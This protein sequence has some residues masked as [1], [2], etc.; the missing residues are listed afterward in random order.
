MI[1][2][3]MTAKWTGCLRT[4][5]GLLLP[6][7]SLGRWTTDSLLDHDIFLSV[8]LSEPTRQCLTNNNSSYRSVPCGTIKIPSE[9]SICLPAMPAVSRPSWAKSIPLLQC[10]IHEPPNSTEDSPGD[11]QAQ[12]CRTAWGGDVHE[13]WETFVGGEVRVSWHLKSGRAPVISGSPR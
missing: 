2:I 10:I 5:I 13:A 9:S 7:K 11:S 6:C 12:Q 4:D 8:Q 1:N 3:T